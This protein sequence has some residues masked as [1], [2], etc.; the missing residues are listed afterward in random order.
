MFVFL[1]ATFAL[2]FVLFGVG[3]GSAGIGDAL[4][5]N[6]NNIFGGGGPSTSIGRLQEQTRKHPNDAKAFRDLATALE[7]KKR[8]GEAI[9]AL[10]RY[11][12]LRPKDADALAEL[13]LQYQTQAQELVQQY[14]QAQAASPV[15]PTTGF[16]PPPSTR[17]GKLF[18]DPNA[19]QNPIDQASASLL[20]AKTQEIQ[21]KYIQAQ[22]SAVSAFK[23]L[24]ATDPKDA[25]LQFELG[26][27]AQ[28][29]G[30]VP[31]AIAAYKRYLKLAPSS[32]DAVEIKRR[33]KL[34]TGS[35]G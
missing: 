12:A 4:R 32:Q 21:Q 3:S 16:V 9:A 29:A 18:T 8:T 5:D 30:D 13:A 24:A 2:G 34:L 28:K 14:E 31:T 22:Q 33:L 6:F 20:D 27:A 1:A 26:D 19:L 7:T 35:K 11:T 17:V 15:V 25:N 23:R 10:E